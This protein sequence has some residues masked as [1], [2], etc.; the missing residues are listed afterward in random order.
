MRPS[1]QP[2]KIQSGIQMSSG[3]FP[4][5]YP[6]VNPQIT[7]DMITAR[8]IYCSVVFLQLLVR[9]DQFG[10]LVYPRY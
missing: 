4:L 7:T 5:G 8:I 2:V 1:E 10:F 9:R 6:G 3:V